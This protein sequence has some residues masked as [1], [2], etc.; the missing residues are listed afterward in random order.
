MEAYVK[1]ESS[2]PLREAPFAPWPFFEADEVTA[3]SAV[4]ESGNVNYWTG[5]Q[6]KLFEQEFA[7]SVGVEHA[8]GLTS[9]TVALELA[10]LALGVESGDEVVVTPRTFVACAS[11]AV[12]VGAKPVFAEVDPISQ[13]V[14]AET[15]ES[16]LTNRTR[17]IICVHLAGWP[18]DMDSI[19]DLAR[20]RG[21]K[22]IEDCAQAQGAL[23][24][25]RPVG[26]MGDAGVFSFCQDKIMT[27]GGEGGMLVTNDREVW[28][29][30]WSYKDHGKDFDTVHNQDHPP[31][32]RWIHHSFGTNWRL[33]EIQSALGRVTLPKVSEWLEIRRRNA[34]YLTRRF[35]RIAGLRVTRPPKH[36]RHAFYKYYAF[37][38]TERL[39][40][41]WD[42]DRIMVEVEQE[43]IPC[44][45]G[46]CGEVYQERAF[47]AAGLRPRRRLMNARIL[48]QTSLMFLVHPTL[49][50]DDMEDTAQAVE[51]VMARATW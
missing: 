23:Y 18:C 26:S 34:T 46:S 11:S 3:V 19:M 14:T 13:N 12:L 15:I 47:E 8:V 7:E 39:K 16:V 27:T 9:G 44:F 40:P 2:S 50:L 29:K 37:V 1:N 38:R 45:S 22:V 30:A 35:E 4:L 31:G 28:E 5:D 36:I 21:I 48:G 17:A 10:L 32:F 25:G 51:N 33:T 20:S 49:S 42:R 24:R 6:G 41:G 43:G